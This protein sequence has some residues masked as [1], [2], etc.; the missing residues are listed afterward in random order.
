MASSKTSP[1]QTVWLNRPGASGGTT[2]SRGGAPRAP[3]ALRTSAL[4]LLAISPFL[5]YV[6]LLP[7][8]E[9][10]SVQLEPKTVATPGVSPSPLH[11]PAPVLAQ[12][13][14]LPAEAPADEPVQ[15]QTTTAARRVVAKPETAASPPPA[16]APSPTEQPTEPQAQVPAAEEPPPPPPPPPDA[17]SGDEN[18]CWP[19]C[20]DETAQEG[21]SDESSEPEDS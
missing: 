19:V 6:L 15:Q 2:V 12:E 13:E 8:A 21:S 4:V 20:G 3:R 1:N 14:P 16:P 18:D 10:E 11:S 17:G 9:P 5:A 7:P